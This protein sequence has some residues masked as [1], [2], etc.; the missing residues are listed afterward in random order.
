MEI[1]DNDLPSITE[2]ELNVLAAI[3]KVLA[4]SRLVARQLEVDRTLKMSRTLHL[5]HELYE[6]PWVIE[7][8]ITLFEHSFYCADHEP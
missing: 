1:S 3:I 4:L 5:I 6:T 2:E 7:G 8:A